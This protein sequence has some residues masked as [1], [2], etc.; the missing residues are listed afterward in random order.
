MLFQKD[1][2]H[3]KVNQKGSVLAEALFK[4]KGEDGEGNREIDETIN[5]H[6]KE[7]D[8]RLTDDQFDKIKTPRNVLRGE[9][10]YELTNRKL[11]VII[12]EIMRV[13]ISSH[14]GTNSMTCW[15]V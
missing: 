1:R 12:V 2:Q 4:Y 5:L 7:V 9:T 3:K 13:I 10:Q 11:I 8:R 6:G 15:F 14:W